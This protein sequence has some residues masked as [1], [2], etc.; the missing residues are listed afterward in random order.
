MTTEELAAL[1]KANLAA[2]IKLDADSKRIFGDY[3]E[4]EPPPR[5]LHL[6]PPLEEGDDG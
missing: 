6:V 3:D 5:H 1:S 2:A 4:D